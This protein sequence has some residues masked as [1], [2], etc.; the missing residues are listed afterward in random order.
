[1][2]RAA[3]R[4]PLGTSG[5]TLIELLVVIAIVAIL[6]ALLLPVLGRAREQARITNCLNQLRQIGFALH[7]Y[8]GEHQERFPV[9]DPLRKGDHQIITMGQAPVLYHGRLIQRYLES[10][11]IFLCPVDRWGMPLR[12]WSPS[13]AT[14]EDRFYDQL[15]SSYLYAQLALRNRPVSIVSEP[16]R[17]IWASEPPAVSYGI[18]GHSRYYF[19]WHYGRSPYVIRAADLPADPQRFISPIL[20]VDG[21]VAVHDFTEKIKQGPDQHFEPTADWMWREPRLNLSSD[22]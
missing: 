22:P 18:L 15:G 6:A 19:H 12:S 11:E 4:R 13:G 3:S 2:Q 20:F 16:A 14:S 21:H 10:D 17:L 1:M 5:F 8:L 7:L 9:G